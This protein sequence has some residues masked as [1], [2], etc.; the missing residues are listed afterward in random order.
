MAPTVP[1]RCWPRWRMQVRADHDQGAAA[2]PRRAGGSPRTV[3][4]STWL[5]TPSPARISDRGDP[6]G[7]GRRYRR[8]RIRLRRLSA[9]YPMHRLTCWPHRDHRRLRATI[10]RARAA[11][12]D[13][14]WRADYTATRPKVERKIGHLMRRRHGGRRARIRG[15][16]KAAADFSLLAAAVNLA[17]LG[18]LGLR[19]SRGPRM[20]GLPSMTGKPLPDSRFHTTTDP[21]EPAEDVNEP[22]PITTPIPAA[23]SSPIAARITTY[24]TKPI[25]HQRPRTR[26]DP[27]HPR[28]GLRLSPGP[29]RPAACG[30]R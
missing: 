8:I 2:R 1:G 6:P 24:P 29:A 26:P 28:C 22:Q 19:S 10:G 25:R 12:A 30:S 14:A 23:T 20:A 27:S 3:S 15:T 4:I 9:G 5:Q 11:Q 18:V 17:R 13:P 16:T 21:T 7:K